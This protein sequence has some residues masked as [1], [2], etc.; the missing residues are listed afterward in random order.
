MI[1]LQQARLMGVAFFIVFS[2]A[3]QDDA[4]RPNMWLVAGYGTPIITNSPFN[5][6]GELEIKLGGRVAESD[7]TLVGG[8]SNSLNSGTTNPE[9]FSLFLGPGY[10]FTDRLIFFSLHTGV[11]YPFYR[12]APEVQ[13]NVSWYNAIDLG[14]KLVPKFA[15]GIGFNGYISQEVPAYHLRFMAIV[16]IY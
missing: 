3:A 2:L 13:Q 1:R 14:L 11:S 12:N 10:L 16:S 6:G 5:P 4:T 15:V 8:L 7:L 9:R